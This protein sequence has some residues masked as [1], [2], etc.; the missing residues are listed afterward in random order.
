M[1]VYDVPA[2][3]LIQA[4]A[5]DLKN[6]I[7]MPQWAKFVKT[8]PHRERPP[9]QPDWWWIRAASIL[10]RVFIDG[11]VGVE[12]LRTWYGGRKDF[13][14]AP[15]HHVDA[16]GKII[17]TILQQLE[18]LGFVE[19]TPKGRR[20]TPK[21]Q[22]YLDNMAKKVS[23]SGGGSSKGRGGKKKGSSSA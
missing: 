11:P 22:K 8:G 3:A 10:R 20:I 16:G 4:V 21:G 12:R 19:K 6:K 9:E 1:G 7:E 17:R 15:E 14:V 5:Q 23:G 2:D 18:S 13:G